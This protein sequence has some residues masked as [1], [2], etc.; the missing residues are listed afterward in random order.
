MTIDSSVMEDITQQ[1][2]K[3]MHQRKIFLRVLWNKGLSRAQLKE[4]LQLSFPSVS[5]L[6][7]EMIAGGV[8]YEAGANESNKRGRP[9]IQLQVNPKAFAVPVVNMTRD[10]Y[11]YTLF[12]A[13]VQPVQA[14]F[15]PYGRPEQTQERWQP[16]TSLICDRLAELMR[17]L[18]KDHTIHDMVICV[19]GSFNS[20]GSLSSSAL[21]IE[22]PEDFISY[23]E[24]SSGLH[25]CLINNS[26]AEAF[27]ERLM[28]PL[29][30]DF[31]FMHVGKGVGAGIIRKGKI[32]NSNNVMRA[33]EIG[34]NSID[35]N[36]IP[37]SC[38]GR[39]CLERYICIPAIRQEA[40]RILG[41]ENV[42][43]E[44]VCR[45][46]AQENPQIVE[47]LNEK[48]RLL[49][50]GISNM[51]A[52][53]PVTHIVLGGGIEQLGDRF[54]EQVQQAMQT[55]GFRKYMNR[56]T[57]TYTVAPSGNGALGAAWNYLYHQIQIEKTLKK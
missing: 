55:V 13:C 18:Q 35:Y 24:E 27:T 48:A 38:G 8:L 40:S 39:G 37:C 52:I 21:W 15:I 11:Q 28:Q 26:D 16:E 54:L 5:A 29:P 25:I 7:E 57:V 36:G 50:I 34:H 22:L 43:F 14:G 53:H 47:M 9:S 6:V 41:Q 3:Y 10:G 20:R 32:Y 23:M 42:D 51:I 46:Y 49:A 44:T 33:G 45:A 56:L 31:I 19:P 17:K 12:D 30:R 4:E 1:Q 2:I